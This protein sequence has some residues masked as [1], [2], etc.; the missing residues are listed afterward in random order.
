[1][2]KDPVCSMNVNE[3]TAKFK[4]EY[5]GKIYYFCCQSCKTAFDKNPDKYASS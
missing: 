4:S 1:M 3:K 2:V 5:R